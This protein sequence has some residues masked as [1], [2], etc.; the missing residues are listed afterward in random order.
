M[1]VALAGVTFSA[2]SA[3]AQSVAIDPAAWMVGEWTGSSQLGVAFTLT[4]DAKGGVTYVFGGRTLPTGPA[5]R[6]GDSVKFLLTSVA[7]SYI[8]LTPT[9]P[10]AGNWMFVG[11]NTVSRST[12]SRKRA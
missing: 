3:T 8:R 4:I 7:G 12:I 9:G 11:G 1:S 5:A 2:P 6:D 10:N